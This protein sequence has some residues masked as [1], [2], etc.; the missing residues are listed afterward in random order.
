MTNSEIV[1]A[2]GDCVYASIN[3]AGRGDGYDVEAYRLGSRYLIR[4]RD[5]AGRRS[6]WYVAET[7]EGARAVGSAGYTPGSAPGSY[8]YVSQPGRLRELRSA[9]AKV[10][11]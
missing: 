6:S 7:I 4:V 5:V 1:H 11:S 8:R 2:C 9:A 3:G 10:A